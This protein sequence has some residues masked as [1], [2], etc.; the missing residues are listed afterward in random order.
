MLSKVYLKQCISAVMGLV[1]GDALGVPAEFLS[2]AELKENPITDMIGYGTH[3][4][5]AGTWSDDSSMTIATI[6]WLGENKES[7]LNYSALM[8]KFSQ[9]IMYGEYTPYGDNFDNGISTSRALIRYSKGIEPL[10]CGGRAENEN[11]NGSLMRILPAALFFSKGLLD[12]EFGKAEEIFNISALTHAHMRSKLGCLIYSKLVADLLHIPK[13]NKHSIV[14]KSL[15]QCRE[16]LAGRA[17]EEIAEEMKKY[18]RLWD[19]EVFMNLH[20]DQIKSSGYVVHTLEA[21][22]WCFLNTDSYRDCVLC[23][24]NLGDDTDTV[25]AVAGGLAG[26]YYGMDSIPQSWLN[27]IPKREWIIELTERMICFII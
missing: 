27:L 12:A 9:W 4:Q 19:A 1:V 15:A 22:I 5:P 8:D 10:Q 2:R 3:E 20:E 25:S 16:Y 17:D 24:V 23:A 14:T 21:A 18:D 11:G 13:S 26:L 7:P 6:E